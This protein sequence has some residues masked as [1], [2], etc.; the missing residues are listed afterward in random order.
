MNFKTPEECGISS[1]N[2]EKYI[3]ALEEKMLI[4]HDVIIAKGD[5]IIFEKYWE[6][7]NVSFLHRQYS[8]TKSVV[9]LAV[10][11][12]IDDGLVSLDDP[13]SK[14]FPEEVKRAKTDLI[15][16]QTVR[17]MLMMSTALLPDNWFK[18]K[19][20]DRVKFY[21]ENSSVDNKR[22]SGTVFHY[23]SEGSFILCAMVER[24]T[25]K[26]F[27]EYMRE[28]CF[29]K[30]G[31]SKGATCLTC[32]GG[33]SWGDS[34]LLCTARDLYLIARFTMNLGKW[35][36]E[37][38][39][40]EQYLKDAT[41]PLI[42]SVR[43]FS[44]GHDI[45][46]YGY[47]I[48]QN[49]DN[50]FSFNGMGCQSAICVPDKDLIL[51]YNGDNQGSDHAKLLI[52]ELFFE[53]IVRAE[54]DIS[55]E[56]EQQSS[57]NEY[58][59]NLHLSALKG[60]KSSPI[61]DTVSGKVFKLLPNPMEIKWIRLNLAKN[62][63]AYLE[64]ENKTGTKRIYFSMLKNFFDKFPEEGYSDNIGGQY[65]KGNF[66]NSATSA[67]WLNHNTLA[68]QVLVIDKYFGRLCIKLSF[69]DEHTLGVCMTPFAE[70]F[71]NEY[72]GYAEGYSE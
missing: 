10:G 54:H 31:V 29:D 64:Y 70:N 72:S 26:K 23:D 7:F 39:L 44:Y 69:K 21:F 45:F 17:E 2:V 5:D 8:I 50:S 46:G 3:R 66:Y 43:N 11:F 19:C 12:A 32:P 1:R 36:G 33:H 18:K 34:A 38:L 68:I 58:T 47:Y 55:N 28:K 20:A 60:E 49:F 56:N 37:Q 25:G 48:W 53:H 24:L 41:S 14:Y 42:P 35:N 52:P 15:K 4:T 27:I 61:Q 30:I 51:I 59:K 22:P 9:A 16:N 71:F 57:L 13:I 40:S 67:A 62:S 65:A 6:P 63:R